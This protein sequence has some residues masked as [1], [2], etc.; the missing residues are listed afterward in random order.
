V[1]E[2]PEPPTQP[3]PVEAAIGGICPRCGKGKLFTGW[4]K[5][6]DRCS[7]CALDFSSFN[8]GDGPVVFLTFGIGALVTALAVTVELMFSPG[9]VIHALLWVP[10]TT[11][12]VI[13]GLRVTKGLLLA[14]EFANA[15]REG[16]IRT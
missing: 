6:A 16:R 14:L 5:F 9:I 4:I 15:A 11:V 8:V 10:L 2:T 1:S 13:G 12:L 7:N 3:S